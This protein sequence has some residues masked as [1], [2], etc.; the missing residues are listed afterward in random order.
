MLMKDIK[1]TMD[2]MILDDCDTDTHGLQQATEFI[3]GIKDL[4]NAIAFY[5]NI[6]TNGSNHPMCCSGISD[7]TF[8][9]HQQHR[10]G[11]LDLQGWLIGRAPNG[12]ESCG[13]WCGWSSIIS[14]INS[15]GKSTQVI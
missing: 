3:K 12:K 15:S 5:Y 7:C 11:G 6:D 8:R 14:N 9:I 13:L 4:S 1:L 10:P 2:A